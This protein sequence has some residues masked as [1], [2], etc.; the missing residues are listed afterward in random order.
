[1]IV[2][3]I[4]YMFR[5]REGVEARA[6]LARG[7][8]P[9][10]RWTWCPPPTCC[11]TPHP[12]TCTT[13]T[14][15]TWTLVI[16]SNRLILELSFTTHILYSSNNQSFCCCCFCFRTWVMKSTLCSP[17]CPATHTRMFRYISDEDNKNQTFYLLFLYIL[18]PGAGLC[19]M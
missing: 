15:R 16:G 5:R 9:Y 6:V 14:A 4:L 12:G 17:T 1:M 19:L 7:V 18:S 3:N 13:G 8:S 10:R 11:S 2:F